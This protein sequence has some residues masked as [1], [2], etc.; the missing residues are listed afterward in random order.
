MLASHMPP[1]YLY[2]RPQSSFSPPYAS[3]KQ[4]VVVK[5][6]PTELLILNEIQFM[7]V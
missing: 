2:Q 5:S 7:Y 1:C 6:G 3:V 4:T